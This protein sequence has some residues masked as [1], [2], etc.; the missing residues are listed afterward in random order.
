MST[1]LGPSLNEPGNDFSAPLSRY[2][3]WLH[4]VMET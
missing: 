4:D 3:A 1:S 2:S